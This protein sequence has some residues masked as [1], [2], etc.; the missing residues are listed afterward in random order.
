MDTAKIGNCFEANDRLA[1][2]E[3]VADFGQGAGTAGDCHQAVGAV[4]Y[5]YIASLA[6]VCSN[7]Y[8]DIWIS[9]I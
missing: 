1:D 5:N 4:S 2:L 3:A 6:H 9:T 7:G 8:L